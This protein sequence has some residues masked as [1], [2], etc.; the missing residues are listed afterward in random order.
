MLS[1]SFLTS[2]LELV[3]ASAVDVL[4]ALPRNLHIPILL[5]QMNTASITLKIVAFLDFVQ[6]VLILPALALTVWAAWCAHEGKLREMTMALAG[7][8]LCT[9]AVPIVKLLAGIT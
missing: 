7:A 5:A 1:L 8:F 2:A 9:V 3:N 6:I 4:S